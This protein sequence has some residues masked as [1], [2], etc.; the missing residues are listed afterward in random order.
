MRKKVTVFLLCMC[1]MT[2]GMP[3][4][5][6]AESA[7]ETVQGTEK[8]ASP[9]KAEDLVEN[10]EQAEQVTKGRAAEYAGTVITPEDDA[11]ILYSGTWNGIIW[12]LDSN[13][14]LMLDGSPKDYG[15]VSSTPWW[16]Y[17]DSIVSAEVKGSGW[18]SA[19]NLFLGCSNLVQVDM[20]NWDTSSVTNMNYM[21]YGCSGLESLDLSGFEM[22]SVTDAED[23]FYGCTNLDIIYAPLNLSVSVE[24]PS[25]TGYIW[26]LP[27]GTKIKTLP[28]NLEASVMITRVSGAYDEQPEIITT[29]QDLN[30]ADIVRVKYVP[31]S[32]TLETDN[33]DAE[34]QIT[35]SIAEGRLPEGLQIYPATGE[36]YGVPVEAGE[37]PITVKAAYSNLDFEPSFAKLTVTVLD[38]TDNNVYSAS[39]PGYEVIVP[40][41]EKTEAGSNV[42]AI[43]KSGD[44]LFVSKGEMNEF[45]GLWLNGQK[46]EEL[47]DYSV[48]SGSTRITVYGETF[49]NKADRDGVN[50]IAAEFRVDG[51][52]NKSLKRTAQNFRLA[53]GGSIGNTENTGNTAKGL[54]GAAGKNGSV[55][56]IWQ[57]VDA[58]GQPYQ[59]ITVELHSTLM[60]AAADRR[61]IAVFRGVE[62]GGHTLTV[63]DQSNAVLADKGFELLFGDGFRIDGDRITAKSGS[64]FT[65]T[66]QVD[67]GTLTL[68]RIQEGDIYRVIAPRT[69]D[70]ENS[71]RLAMVVLFGSMGAA[72]CLYGKKRRFTRI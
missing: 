65:V 49:E 24:L 42:Y 39:D 43:T 28:Q 3:W 44:Q 25:A 56:A 19:S 32:Y 69:D 21:F 16:I 6:S 20:S 57:I 46:L 63:K 15:S 22:G 23:M 47:K 53:F 34:N 38:S 17:S 55:T 14:K 29:T 35:F 4:N 27:D 58:A 9:E 37:F 1:L 70:A 33:T 11:E 48:E 61:G 13:G 60:T 36:I 26:Q 51:D 67:N 7:Q 62:G 50:T 72:L 40:L 59:N 5:V 45:V 71:G 10:T 31:Y 54:Q 52:P 12:S 8:V 66:A 18:K 41:G 2:V 68:V 30:M 64:V